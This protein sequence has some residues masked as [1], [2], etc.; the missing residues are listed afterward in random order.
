MYSDF[1]FVYT[2]IVIFNSHFSSEEFA[3]YG[4]TLETCWWVECV[5]SITGG[6]SVY[7]GLSDIGIFD[8]GNCSTKIASTL[9]NS[10]HFL[11]AGN[12]SVMPGQLFQMQVKLL[13]TNQ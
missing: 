6:E 4:S 9:V 1:N 10:I 2:P 11:T 3:V 7:D 12:V 5:L 13:A 8:V